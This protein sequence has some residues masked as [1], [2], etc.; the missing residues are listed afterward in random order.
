[1]K[2]LNSF[3]V[4]P[5]NF[6]VSIGY[7]EDKKYLKAARKWGHFDKE[8]FAKNTSQNYSALVF[9]DYDNNL[10]VLILGR[11]VAMSEIVHECTHITMDAFCAAGAEID[12]SNQ[13]PF[14]YCI[15]KVYQ[16]VAHFHQNNIGETL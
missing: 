4:E 2:P 12:V 11:D 16:K 1:M 7:R 15:Q 5:F 14:A 13:E 9:T 6:T 8:S 10:A 3:T